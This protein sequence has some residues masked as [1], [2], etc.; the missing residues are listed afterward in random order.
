MGIYLG[1]IKLIRIKR[2]FKSTLNSQKTEIPPNF[3]TIVILHVIQTYLTR[4][5]KIM[6]MLRFYQMKDIYTDWNIGLINLCFTRN[7]NWQDWKYTSFV[8]FVRYSQNCYYLLRTSSKT[9]IETP[10]FKLIFNPFTFTSIM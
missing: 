9:W 4:K 1:I 2:Q 7:I 10:I 5:D 8:V 6:H 3:V